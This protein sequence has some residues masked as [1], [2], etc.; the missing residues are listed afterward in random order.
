M[1]DKCIDCGEETPIKMYTT[2][3]GWVSLCKK[4]SLYRLT[5]QKWDDKDD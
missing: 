3:L 5:G 4:C 2:N 1:S